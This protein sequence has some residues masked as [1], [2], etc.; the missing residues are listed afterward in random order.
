MIAVGIWLVSI[1]LSDLVAGLSGEPKAGPRTIGAIVTGFAAPF[2]LGLASGATTPTPW[3][4]VPS[5]S[6][7]PCS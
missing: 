4:R 6:G 1:G 2:V 7:S 3:S 5:R